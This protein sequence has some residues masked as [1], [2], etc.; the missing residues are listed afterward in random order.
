MRKSIRKVWLQVEARCNAAE[1]SAYYGIS[2]AA[3]RVWMIEAKTWATR[4]ALA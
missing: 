2:E 4:R 3:A 1:I